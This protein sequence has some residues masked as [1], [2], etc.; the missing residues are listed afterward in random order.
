MANVTAI[1]AV[2]LTPNNELRIEMTAIKDAVMN[3]VRIL[4]VAA[5][6]GMLLAQVTIL[7]KGP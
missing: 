4:F 6:I 3:V 7:A 2:V 5:W 1:L